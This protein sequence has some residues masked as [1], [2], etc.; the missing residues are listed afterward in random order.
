MA[1]LWRT[2]ENR[3]PDADDSELAGLSANLHGARIAASAEEVLRAG[4]FPA[5]QPERQILRV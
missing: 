2:G 3:H 5:R 1:E 4:A